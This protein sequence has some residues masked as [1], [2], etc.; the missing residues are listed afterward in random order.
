MME[1]T[2][3]ALWMT[4]SFGLE[5]QIV[6]VPKNTAPSWTKKKHVMFATC[7][8]DGNAWNSHNNFLQI[9]RCRH[10]QKVIVT[11]LEPFVH[12]AKNTNECFTKQTTDKC[13]DN[14]VSDRQLCQCCQ[15]TW[16]QCHLL[17]LLQKSPNI[18]FFLLHSLI[19]KWPN[20]LHMLVSW[21][22]SIGWAAWGRQ[23]GSQWQI[24][25][26]GQTLVS[27]ESQKALSFFLD[28]GV[29]WQFT[30]LGM[31]M[32][33]LFS[34]LSWPWRRL[35]PRCDPSCC[36]VSTECFVLQLEPIAAQL[37]MNTNL[38]CLH[39]W[40]TIL[41]GCKWPLPALRAR[42]CAPCQSSTCPANKPQ[43]LCFAPQEEEAQDGKQSFK[44]D[45]IVK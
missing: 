8:K 42:C 9:W 11:A 35:W 34:P 22:I 7:Q 39:S 44:A 15:G 18:V 21:K 37:K 43:R 31:L 26:S 19:V 16:Q 1:F 27:S 30:H 32:W 41:H 17:E 23:L 13:S 20:A 33:P 38:L 24:L 6:I 28:L 40:T 5:P 29:W 3:A 12:Q 45:Y 25:V 2:G 4:I 14:S 36:L 10:S